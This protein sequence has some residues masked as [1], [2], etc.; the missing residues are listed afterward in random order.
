M[1]LNDL[2]FCCADDNGEIHDRAIV[3]RGRDGMLYDVTAKKSGDTVELSI[4]D[5]TQNEG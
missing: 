1:T 2:L 3:L 4:G 5:K